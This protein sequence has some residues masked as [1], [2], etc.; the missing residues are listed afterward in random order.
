MLRPL[1]FLC[2][3]FANNVIGLQSFYISELFANKLGR[4][5][6][7]GSLWFELHNISSQ[8]ILV[9]HLLL[10]IVIGKEKPE[11]GAEF[12]FP[13]PL[14]FEERLLLA[15]REDLGFD[16][17]HCLT[18]MVP[19][20]VL[21]PFV[22]E[23]SKE[24]KIC[25]TVNRSEQD[26]TTLNAHQ[27]FPDGVALYRHFDGSKVQ[28]WWLFEPC[29]LYEGVFATPGLSERAC[30][31][32]AAFATEIIASCEKEKS[33][34][35]VRILTQGSP[36]NIRQISDGVILVEDPDE[37][38]LW[39]LMQCRSPS[40]SRL[41]CHEQGPPLSINKMV[42]TPLKEMGAS[43]S[44]TLHLNYSVR[45][46]YSYKSSVQ[47]SKTM[48]EKRGLKDISIKT[49]LISPQKLLMGLNLDT[50]DVPL[51][52]WIKDQK[53]QII[54]AGAWS[55]KGYKEVEIS[56]RPLQ[57]TVSIELL[58][59]HEKHSQNIYKRDIESGCQ[60]KGNHMPLWM[61]L[62]AL[63]VIIS[64]RKFSR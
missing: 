50:A 34:S 38:D 23:K 45:D 55:T 48:P 26:C 52:Y 32:D 7:F 49:E 42:N 9:S 64:G 25:V 41:I 12:S 57:E 56:M 6:N 28:P 36:P 4:H 19:L 10:E 46:L 2:G 51:N 11:L 14:I 53:G 33:K 22:L 63:F 21:P 35:Q 3:I 30:V 16:F 29:Q 17:N 18:K 43:P 40:S 24:L 39:R 58:G 27:R 61:I 15:Q 20:I 1:L 47:S 62:A 44:E 13:H 31:L 60:T 37:T 59:L 54:H 5:N 8:N